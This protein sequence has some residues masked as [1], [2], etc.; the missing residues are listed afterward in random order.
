[1]RRKMAAEA[2]YVC[3]P[4]PVAGISVHRWDRELSPVLDPGRPARSHGLGAGVK[5]DRIRSMLIQVAEAGALPAAERIIGDRDRNRHV[6]PD[7]ADLDLGG[8][9]ARRVA[10]AGEEG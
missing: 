5:A 4:G 8:E 2:H 1:M 7:H 9:V 3:F 6:D 10:V